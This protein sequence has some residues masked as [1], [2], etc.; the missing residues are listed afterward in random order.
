MTTNYPSAKDD[1][2]SIPVESTGTPLSTNHIESHTNVRDA[3]IALQTKVGVDGDATTT[4][5][6]YKLS[7]VTG[8][9]KAASLT[10]AETL[11]N[12][13]IGSGTKISLGSDATGDVYYRN[14]GGNKTRLGIGSE[15]DILAVQSGL[16][17]WISNPATTD[18]STTER[19][20][21]EKATAAEINAGTAT[22]GAGTLAVTPDQLASSDYIKLSDVSVDI[23][24]FTSSGTWTKPTGAKKVHVQAVGGGG[25]G[26]GGNDNAD[27]ASGGGGGEYREAWFDADDLGSSETVT[28][29][30]GGTAATN[31]NGV[32]GSDTTFG[33]E[34][35]AKGG[36]AGTRTT[37]STATTG[38]NGG[39][40]LG[41]LNTMWGAGAS[42][43]IGGSGIYSGAG[44]GAAG[45]GTPYAGGSSIY[46]GAGG[47]GAG[48]SAA[49]GGTSVYGGNGGASS[50]DG[51][52]TAGTQ[53]GGGGGGTRK[54]GASGAGAAG[55]VIVTTYF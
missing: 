9:D 32:A 35:T 38:G 14:A 13:T 20:V 51:A 44:G 48:T 27:R 40:P 2:T 7:G 5:H 26:A 10:G 39:S 42:A 11:T 34:L 21:V 36:A 23:Q 50:A 22:G 18:A 3:V 12:K 49:S 47:A 45:A 6:D 55:Q 53:P 8:S 17:A 52:G 1:N 24:T 43:A 19:G 25:S 31:G 33:S 46:G 28:I 37:F 4:S 15:N 16:P 54:N 29:G 30:A 41:T